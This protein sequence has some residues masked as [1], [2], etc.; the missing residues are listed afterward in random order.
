MR[1][2]L[3]LAL[4]LP[5]IAPLV[6]AP[7]PTPAVVQVSRVLVMPFDVT[8]RAEQGTTYWM[9]EAAA[10]LVTD[11]LQARGYPVFTRAE[12]AAAFE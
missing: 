5:S 2:L 10:L 6:A 11:A 9:G 8:P 7:A 3:A 12:R 4:I 1:A